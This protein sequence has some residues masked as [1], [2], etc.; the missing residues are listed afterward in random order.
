MITPT[1]DESD[2]PATR[3]TDQ[4]P[5]RLSGGDATRSRAADWDRAYIG[6]SPPWDIGRPQS[7]FVRLA[8]A[9]EIRSP[10]L[11]SGCGTGE[12]A[13]M[14]AARGMEVVGVDLAPT[15]IERA[16]QKARERGLDPRLMV[17]DAL[18][19]G[20]LDRRFSTVIDSGVFHVFDDADRA[21]YVESLAEALEPG[22]VLHVLC[23]SDHVP[24]S[25]GPR[26]V[27]QAELRAAFGEGWRFERIEGTRFEVNRSWPLP[28][29]PHAW[30]AKIVRLLD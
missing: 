15:A 29:P 1:T 2:G 22:G 10:V 13:L 8:D 25:F 5:T 20:R 11:D 17:G 9:A 4:P 27:S 3:M 12:N 18:E 23:F 19:L 30:L 6:G 21:R 28:E 24:G 26:R 14:L 7:V 16:R